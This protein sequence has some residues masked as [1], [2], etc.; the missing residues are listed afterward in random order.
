[1][2][3]DGGVLQRISVSIAGLF[4]GLALAVPAC[5]ADPVPPPVTAKPGAAKTAVA[6]AIDCNKLPNT[7]PV[8]RFVSLK[9]TSAMLR[10]G[11][12]D[13]RFPIAYEYVRAGLPI[14]I[15]REYC[16]WRQ[17][18]EPDGTTGWMNMAL[19][20]GKRTGIV[21]GGIRLLYVAPDLQSRI[22]W[23]I[24]PGTIVVITLCEN[25]WCRVSNGGRSGYILR[26][27]MWGTYP[28]EAIGG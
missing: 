18:R 5:A 13:R 25:V 1:V 19:L 26:N 22:A 14:E 11:P 3:Q 27:Q 10:T 8:P 16:T 23:R 15:T 20:T 4:A 17:V 6:K 21:Q 2:R 12:D 7:F 24:E 9:S 28:N